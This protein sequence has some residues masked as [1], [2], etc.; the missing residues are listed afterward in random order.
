MDVHTKTMGT[1][2]VDPAH[3]LE[4]PAGLFGFEDFHRFALLHAEYE[5]FFWLQ[6]LDSPQ[7]AF[8]LVDPF[9]IISDYEADVD[10]RAL[11]EIELTSPS[12]V[13]IF[14]IVTVPSSGGPVTANLQGP[15][16]IN[17]KNNKAMQVILSNQKW[18][19]KHDIMKAVQA[20]GNK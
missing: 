18:K 17:R 9:I 15:L 5:P 6:S 10:D 19:T 7:L 14:A 20:R 12:D 2:S 8:L 3:I 13:C 16:V 4:F 11:S 1:V